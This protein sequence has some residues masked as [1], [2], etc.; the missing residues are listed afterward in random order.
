M[1]KISFNPRKK[2]WRRYDPPPSDTSSP[3]S[4][5]WET[6]PQTKAVDLRPWINTPGLRDTSG[7]FVQYDSSSDSDWESSDQEFPQ[8]TLK[9]AYKY[10]K[11]S[12]KVRP[13]AALIPEEQKPKRHFP[14]DPL[15]NLP[16]L[17]YHAPQFTPTPKF[18][19]E[20][21]KKL[22]IDQHEE[23]WPEERKLLQHVLSINERSIAFNEDERGTFR[24]DYFSDYIIPTV[25]HK[26]WSERNIPLPPGYRDE[27]IQLLKAKIK[28]GVYEPA[29]TAYRSK[30]FYVKKKDGGMRIVHDLQQ[31]NGVTIQDS[32]VPPIIEEFVEAYAGR[33]VYT[34]LDMYWGFHARMLDV[35]SRDYTAFQT[36]L[37]AFRLTSLPMGYTNAPAE[38]QACMMFVLQDEV[39]EVAGVF[40]DDVPIKGPATRYLQPDGTEE[41]I[42]QNPG[43]RR[44]IWEH[45]NDIHRILHR[46]GEAGGTVSGKKMQLCQSEVTIVGHQCSS[47]GREPVDERVERVVHWPQPINLKEVRGFL[48]LCGTVRMWIKDFSQLARPLVHLVKKGVTFQWTSVQQ[49]AFDHLKNLVTKA[50]VV[51]PIDYRSDQPVILSVDTSKYGIGFILSQVKENGL[52]SPARYGSLP[53]PPPAKNYPQPKLELYGLYKSLQH[54]QLH[55]LGIRKLVVEVDAKYIKGM[56]NN[57]DSNPDAVLNRWIQGVLLFNFEL[58]HVPASKH[59]G[60]DALSRRRYTSED[61][62]STDESDDDKW[63]EFFALP[64]QLYPQL[65]QEDS[66]SSSSSEYEIPTP[67]F[68]PPPYPLPPSHDETSLEVSM[69]M[70]SSARI[71]HKYSEQ[72]LV[73]IL[74]F[75]VTNQMPKL[76]T[77]KERSHFLKKADP[78]FLKETHMYLR[79]ANH[80]PQVVIFSQKRRR[81]IL[82]EMHEDLAH[83]GVWAVE[84]QVALR[85]FW[86]GMQKQIKDHV[87]SCHT[88]Q[89]R[90]TKKMH[91]PITISHPLAVFSKVYLDVMKMPPAKRLQWLTCAKDDL[92]GTS[93]GEGQIHDNGQTAAAF[94]L[95]NI[96]LRYGM[97]LEVVTD[98]GPAYQKEFTKFLAKYGIKH[99]K[100]SPYNSQANGVVERGHYNIRE[101]LVKLCKGKLHHW[102][103]MLPAALFADRVTVRKATGYSPYYLLH[104][105]HPLMPGDLADATFLVTDFKPGMTHQEL[106]QARTRQ[107]LRL[108][109]DIARA[110]KILRQSR[111]R[112]KEAFEKKFARRIIREAY[113]PGD[114]VLIRNNPIENS[115]SIERK[116]ADRYMGPYQVIRQTQGGSYTLAEM[117]GDEL[118]HPLA[119]FRLIPYVQ[120]QD[121]DSWADEIELSSEAEEEPIQEPSED[122]DQDSLQETQSNLSDS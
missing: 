101:A 44:F 57:P 14:E 9:T 88:C 13:V 17:P 79:R 21:M 115:V 36:P 10:K 1:N 86:P 27:L 78:F 116:T 74:R 35:L 43:I 73:D 18:T 96:I 91:L 99:I 47:Q 82:W 117:T 121:L 60:P 54:F 65:V 76:K 22:A 90:S 8:D 64:A 113:A 102:P 109:E 111:F 72:D 40:I 89:L 77:A 53:L 23:L 80:S 110:Q 63:M 75:L 118:A 61:N 31:L 92:T 104:G 33:S 56:L 4:S 3:D 68:Y 108:P 62:I 7:L 49:A 52:R 84:Q 107:L 59:Q 122:G 16:P 46:I 51:Q 119:A 39:P 55:L 100:I 93:E 25:P 58:V 11:V 32:A 41:T 67:P 95:R 24:R 112:S 97:L 12:Q 5:D 19:E 45:L 30:W 114:L 48:G 81:E 29:T 83:H 103:Q 20:R 94:F 66:S 37:G 120:R 98:N 2:V 50:P 42:P 87:R 34:V 26:P 6:D 71:A 38:F 15:R 105:I 70:A 28:A 106:L 85:Y 69:K